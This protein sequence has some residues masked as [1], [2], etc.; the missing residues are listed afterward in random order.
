MFNV[1]LESPLKRIIS[2]VFNEGLK[3][4]DAGNMSA[5][6]CRFVIV[7]FLVAW[8]S[9]CNYKNCQATAKVTDT[10]PRNRNAPLTSA[11][12]KKRKHSLMQATYQQSIV[13]LLLFH[14][15]L[16]G[17]AHVISKIAKQ[18]PMLLVHIH[19]AGMFHL[20]HILLNN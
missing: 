9:T 3:R 16:H 5:K 7:S 2:D 6:Y 14:S 18:Q 19:V 8:H 10:Y 1:A 4:L 15:L 20:H 11:G 12:K 17:T 13:D